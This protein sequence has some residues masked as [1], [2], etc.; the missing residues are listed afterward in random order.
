LF[1]SDHHGA[2]DDQEPC[3]GKSQ[4]LS[5]AKDRSGEWLDGGKTYRLTIPA[6]PPVK[7]FWSILMFD[8]LARSIIQTDTNKAGGSSYDKLQK[9]ADGSIDLWFGPEA[10]VE[11]GS[12]WVKTLAGE[13]WFAY[14]RAYSQTEVFSPRHG[15][16]R[17]SMK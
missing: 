13:E 10:P 11:K 3:G 4:Y 16:C 8:N 17:I 6:N 5:A 15:N 12:N 14:F 2:G 1:R 9:D 7:E